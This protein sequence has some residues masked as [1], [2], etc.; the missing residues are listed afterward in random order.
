MINIKNN[1]VELTM[2][3]IQKIA[4]AALSEAL[5]TTSRQYLVGNLQKPQ[6]LEHIHDEQVEVGVSF[7]KEFTAD[8]PHYHPTVSEYQ[9]VIEGSSYIKNLQTNEII[10]L[11][12]GDFYIVKANT[13]Y[14]QKNMPNTKILFFKHPGLNDK[15]PVEVDKETEIWMGKIE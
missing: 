2:A 15:I 8:Q 3:G 5:E 7:Y 14:A 10:K 12:A 9:Y 11:E 1:K 6:L 4:A 13:P